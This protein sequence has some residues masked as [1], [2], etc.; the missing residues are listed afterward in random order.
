MRSSHYGLTFQRLTLD[1]ANTQQG[2]FWFVQA[3][4]SVIGQAFVSFAE[5]SLLTWLYKTIAIISA[6]GGVGFWFS[7]AKLDVEEG[8]LNVLAQSSFMGKLIG[9]GETKGIS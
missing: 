8:A 9:L 5:N 3:F 2:A 4:S 6:I 7:F 1:I